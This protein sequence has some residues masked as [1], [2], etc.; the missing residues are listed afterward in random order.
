M[1]RAVTL[2]ITGGSGSGKTTIARRLAVAL[3]PRSVALISEDDYYHCSSLFPDFDPATQNFDA[4]AAKDHALLAEHLAAAREGRAFD[5]PIYDFATHTRTP[6]IQ[7]VAP[8]DVV[9]L[10][11]HLALC[12]ARVR[13][14]LDLSVFVEADENVRLGRRMVRDV[15]ERART[16]DSVYRQFF[17]FVRPMHEAHVAPQRAH[18]DMV[19]VSTF[20]GDFAQAEAHAAKIAERVN[21]VLARR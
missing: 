10:D 17:T 13:A 7:T 2:A 9:I 20:D 12:D 3:A 11:G 14:V 16:P 4:P 1:P 6:Q 18:A 15:A 5:K 8:V 21:E 19:V